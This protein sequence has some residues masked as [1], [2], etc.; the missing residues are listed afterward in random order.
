MSGHQNRRP[1]AQPTTSD[2]AVRLAEIM[3][4]A[5]LY[6]INYLGGF[7]PEAIADVIATKA[8][9]RLPDVT[10]EHLQKVVIEK[11][12]SAVRE[13]Q[14][15]IDAATK[16]ARNELPVESVDDEQLSCMV[17]YCVA[18]AIEE[19]SRFLES[20]SLNIFRHVLWPATKIRIANELGVTVSIDDSTFQTWL[21]RD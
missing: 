10:T 20:P 18:D 2:V 1:A 12:R 19:R 8:A 21:G 14:L 13:H 16:C 9:T 15:L 3:N 5:R 17:E 6:V 7:I 11:L 4:F